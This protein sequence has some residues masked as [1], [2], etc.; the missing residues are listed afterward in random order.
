MVHLF[1]SNSMVGLRQNYLAHHPGQCLES[2]MAFGA[3]IPK[4]VALLWALSAPHIRHEGVCVCVRVWAYEYRLIGI[5]IYING[6]CVFLT[7]FI[8]Y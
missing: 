1:A 6:S 7:H 5:Y 8:T 4:H 2:H 3:A